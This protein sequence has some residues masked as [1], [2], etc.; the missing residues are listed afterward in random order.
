MDSLMSHIIVDVVFLV[1]QPMIDFLRG[2]TE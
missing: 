1:T 2:K